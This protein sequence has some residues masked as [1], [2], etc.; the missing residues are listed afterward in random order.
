MI[1]RRQLPE[2]RAFAIAEG[3]LPLRFASEYATLVVPNANGS[4]PGHRWFRYKEAFSA[5]LLEHL[6][7]D[8]RSLR[9]S[10]LTVRMLDPF[11]GVGTALLSA[12]VFHHRI[13][14]LGI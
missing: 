5:D 9:G 10:E 3:K 7:K 2:L 12:Q 1:Y 8:I 14:S 4:A 11:C 13:E 6:L